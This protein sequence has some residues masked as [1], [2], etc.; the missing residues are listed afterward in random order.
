[1]EMI[2][3]DESVP[4]FWFI[5]GSSVFPRRGERERKGKKVKAISKNIHH[6]L[7]LSEWTEKTAWILR[8]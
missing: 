5:A 8:E 1:M 6:L 2:L 7:N 4:S 3:I